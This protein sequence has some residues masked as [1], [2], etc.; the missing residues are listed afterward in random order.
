M[1]ARLASSPGPS[2]TSAG[3]DRSPS[4]IGCLRTAAPARTRARGGSARAWH[5]R[6]GVGVTEGVRAAGWYPDPWGTEGERYFDG[7][8]WGRE[9]RPAG[10]DAVVTDA[11]VAPV[12]PAG[13]DAPGR[14][15]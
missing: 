6:K 11:P 13:P 5:Q 8:A 15:P 10:R 4:F 14:A 9:S 12:T 3:V 7:A 2:T 1:V